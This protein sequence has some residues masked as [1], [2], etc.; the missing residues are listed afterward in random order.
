MGYTKEHLDRMNRSGQRRGAVGSKPTQATRW[1]L[2]EAQH[3]AIGYNEF[4]VDFGAGK[5]AQQTAI[6][7]D[8]G[9]TDVI[10][11]DVGANDHGTEVGDI[12]GCNVV[13]LSNVLNVQDTI[14]NMEQLLHLIRSILAP[15]GR[16]VCN[17]PREPR[18]GN[19]TEQDVETAL[20]TAGFDICGRWK[21]SSGTVWEAW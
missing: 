21:E 18:Y 2:D 10:P 20:K 3:G 7:R 14:E 1:I 19:I 4:V 6:L 11:Y 9:F 15:M 16:L 12:Q 17:L 5:W 8:A 13:L